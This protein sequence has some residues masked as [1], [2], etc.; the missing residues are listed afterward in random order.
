M[1]DVLFK[2]VLDL[3]HE[4]ENEMQIDLFDIGGCS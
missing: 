4:I 3:N 2:I 1:L